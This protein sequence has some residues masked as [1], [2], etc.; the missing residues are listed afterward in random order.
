MIS[1]HPSRFLTGVRGV[2]FDMDGVLCLGDTPMP[3]AADLVAWLQVTGRGVLT[4]TNNARKSPSFFAEKFRRMGMAIPESHVLTSA[5]A[6]AL[7][8]ARMGRTVFVAG[9]PALHAAV[10]EAGCAASDC[11]EV[12]VVGMDIDMGLRPL[13]AAGRYVLAGARLIVT[14]RD[15]VMITDEGPRA[16]A[17][18]A[19]AF[20][21][22]MSGASGYVAGKP[23]PDMFRL[24]LE[25]LGL[26]RENVIMVGDSPLTDIA[27]SSAAGLRS[28]LVGPAVCPNGIRP[29]VQ[30]PDLLT[31]H[32]WLWDAPTE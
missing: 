29:T 32:R 25:T 3:G 16:G 27:G 15:P 10:L 13:E 21:E 20:V 30:A 11:P 9:A 12:V 17:G 31:L 8:A 6:A 19:A 28:V 14:N 18:A 7:A 1:E 4:L 24:G 2:M 22:I 26:P 5:R 23:N